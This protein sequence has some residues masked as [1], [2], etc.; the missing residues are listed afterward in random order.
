MTKVGKWSISGVV[1]VGVLLIATLGVWSGFHLQA[2]AAC[3]GQGQAGFVAGLLPSISRFELVDA[4][5]NDLN[6]LLL[7]IEGGQTITL[8]LGPGQFAELNLSPVALRSDDFLM[9]LNS[10]DL[11]ADAL[12]TSR[13]FR[14]TL[15]GQ[16]DSLAALYIQPD[17]ELNGTLQPGFVS[18][19]LVENV[20]DPASAWTFIEPVRPLIKPLLQPHNPQGTFELADLD[21]CLSR[22]SNPHVVYEAGDTLSVMDLDPTRSVKPGLVAYVAPCRTAVDFPVLF[23]GQMQNQTDQT[24]EA[25][26]ELRVDD[27]AVAAQTL[28]LE[29]GAQTLVDFQHAF[30]ATGQYEAGIA[31][32]TTGF[33]ST[34]LRPIQVEASLDLIELMDGNC[35]GGINLSELQAAQGYFDQ[36]TALP[37]SERFITDDA[38]AAITSFYEKNEVMAQPIAF[39]TLTVNAVGDAA[40]YTLYSDVIEE[41]AWWEGQEELLNLVSAF[42]G[43][44]L[45]SLDVRLGT[46]EAWTEGG[47]GTGI[48]D[49][50]ADG[51]PDINAY[52]VLCQF[53]QGVP[54]STI[55]SHSDSL[56]IGHLF[57][58]QDFAP[59]KVGKAVADTG[60]S[61]C[62]NTCSEAGT[63][64][65]GLAEGRGGLREPGSTS[66]ADQPLDEPRVLNPGGHHSVSQQAPEVLIQSDK[67]TNVN[68]QATLHQRFLL[69]A[70]ELGHTLGAQHS[71]DASSIMHSPMQHTIRFALDDVSRGE[72]LNCLAY[73]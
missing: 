69:V 35:D 67:I 73:C 56:I 57:S 10:F 4:Q 37:I 59:F 27:V 42:Y 23:Q 25:R 12:P 66:C 32:S 13:A 71:T 68:Y 43:A 70:H 38:F 9:K 15:V 34:N 44:E 53:A 64:I 6:A 2:D 24:W 1:V 26:V 7:N 58:G 3:F 29:P 52:T 18:G 45:S 63:E 22:S 5:D 72:I 51:E 36:Q 65:L 11:P 40:F 17:R 31:F 33:S 47:P 14:G 55:H 19:Y 60:D 46:L 39:E 8:A 20:N 41:K 48:P 28:T 50:N 54:T 61:F 49:L 21:V 62:E 30:D 16:P